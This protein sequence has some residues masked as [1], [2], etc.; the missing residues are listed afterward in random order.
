MQDWKLHHREVALAA[1]AAIRKKHKGML[2]YIGAGNPNTLRNLLAYLDGCTVP[3]K[4]G[5]CGVEPWE[6]GV[7]DDGTWATDAEQQVIRRRKDVSRSK[8]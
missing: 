6:R 2:H 7:L 4:G 8:L 5:E 1:A 3:E